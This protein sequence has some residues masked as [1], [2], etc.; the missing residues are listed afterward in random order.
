MRFLILGG[1]AW[2]GGEVVAA[3]LRSGHSVTCLARGSAQRPPDGVH[4]VA[5]DRDGHGAYRQVADEHWDVVLDVSRQPG[6]VEGAV[7]ALVGCAE[8]YVFI[9]SGNVYAD[10][11]LPGQTEQ[12][13]LLPALHG[14]VMADMS[15]YGE[16]KVACEQHV[17]QRFGSGR[18]LIARFGLIGGPGDESGRSGYWPLRFARPAS[19][20]GSVLV[21]ADHELPT[22]LIDVRDGANWLI[23]VAERGLRGNLQRDRRDDPVDR[24]PADRPHCRRPRRTTGDG[25]PSMAARP[26][27]SGVDG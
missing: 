16:A 21:P 27:C 5:A 10:H 1:T 13:T 24:P 25:R 14:P 9:S 18:T 11:R 4:F 22:Q 7:D 12:G 15:Q 19:D 20:D 8:R 17:L 2:L 23:T 6:Q 26:R 3:A